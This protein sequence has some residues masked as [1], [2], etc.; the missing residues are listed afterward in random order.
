MKLSVK[1]MD[2][3]TGDALIG[4]LNEKDAKLMDFHPGDRIKV[5]RGA[6]SET[7]MLNISV[8]KQSVQKGSIGLFEE[9]LTSL[10]LNDR[11][12]VEILPVRKPFSLDLIKKKLDR[13][14]L[15]CSEIRQIVGDIVHN[16][17]SSIELTYFVAACYMNELNK[18]ETLCLTKEMAMHGDKL[19]LSRYPIMDKHCI[20][21]VPETGPQ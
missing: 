18:K 4:I 16:R 2:I 3:A 9:V 20:G 7:V 5:V 6:K 15:S 8:G 11:D 17:L 14:P 19:R 10:Q 1:D 12:Q 21:G 13:L